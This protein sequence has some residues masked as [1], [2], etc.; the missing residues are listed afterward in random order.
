MRPGA[1]AFEAAILQDEHACEDMRG[2]VGIG[3]GAVWWHCLEAI[4][5]RIAVELEEVAENGVGV[6][7]RLREQAEGGLVCADPGC[8]CV[9]PKG[10]F[11]PG[12]VS[13]ESDGPAG[14][15]GRFSV[16]T[17][18]GAD[19]IVGQDVVSGHRLDFNGSV[20][21]DEHEA[22][23]GD[24]A[25]L[26]HV[27]PSDLDDIGCG[28]IKTCGLEVKDAHK[29]IGHG[30]CFPFCRDGC[31]SAIARSRPPGSTGDVYSCL[32]IEGW[33]KAGAPVGCSGAEAGSEGLAHQRMRLR[34]LGRRLSVKSESDQPNPRRLASARGT[35]GSDGYRTTPAASSPTLASG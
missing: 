27:A 7:G 22:R 5:G 18:G 9:G 14:G 13:D 25:I 4:E 29:R 20:G 21:M 17:V 32:E 3:S 19:E 6:S 23:G 2:D 24:F 8:G 33:V 1:H 28:R 34:C 31:G 26:C 30:G 12:V 35:A 15:Q 16:L 10:R 11:E